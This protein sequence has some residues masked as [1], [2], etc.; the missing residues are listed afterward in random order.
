MFAPSR[1]S[2]AIL[3]K[4]HAL[5]QGKLVLQSVIGRRGIKPDWT[6]AIEA[7]RWRALK[8]QHAPPRA[9]N[10]EFLPVWDE[11]KGGAPHA[12]AVRV[13]AAGQEVLLPASFF[14]TAAAASASDVPGI[15]ALAAPAADHDEDGADGGGVTTWELLAFEQGGAPAMQKKFALE[16]DEPEDVRFHAADIGTLL[17]RS[18]AVP[19]PD[20]EDAGA[21]HEVDEVFVPRVIAGRILQAA[22][23]AGA[24]ETGGTLLGR[25]LR[26]EARGTMAAE[27]LAYV[28]AFNAPATLTTLTFTDEHFACVQDT[29]VREPCADSL[30]GFAHSHP[31]SHFCPPS[32]P[33]E[34]RALCPRQRAVLSAADLAMIQTVFPRAYS[35][36]LLANMADSGPTLACFGWAGGSVVRRPYRLV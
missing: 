17:A 31:S 25:L 23:N 3:L 18:E 10:P 34:R 5:E 6:P 8:H 2:F 7:L 16:N 27:V 26:D 1:H 9:L 22:Q 29:L 11:N 30:I 4:R 33:P 15:G 13:R 32:C 24:V 12:R 19:V 21:E 14:Q 35:V 28:P 20:D 36:F